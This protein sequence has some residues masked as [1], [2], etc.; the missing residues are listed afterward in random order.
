MSWTMK[1]TPSSFGGVHKTVKFS[2]G[3]QLSIV[4]H[5][6][7]YGNEFGLWEIA[8][9]DSKYNWRTRTVFPHAKDDV[10][11][12]LTENEVKEYIKIIDGVEPLRD[13]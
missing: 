3:L 11:G 7:S 4:K 8:V 9:M 6:F 12:W 2:N 10:I 1:K 5:C 13:S